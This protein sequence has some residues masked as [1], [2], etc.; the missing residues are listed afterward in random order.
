MP[1]NSSIF[2]TDFATPA[3][4]AFA[5]KLDWSFLYHSSIPNSNVMTFLWFP[6]VSPETVPVPK[7]QSVLWQL[8]PRVTG[9]WPWSHGAMA[10]RSRHPRASDGRV[11]MGQ[12]PNFT[13]SQ[14]LINLYKEQTKYAETERLIEVY[15]QRF[16]IAL[17]LICERHGFWASYLSFL[18]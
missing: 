12:V 13:P 11:R 14:R 10:Y 16:L 6:T 9:P 1:D 2:Q 7:R 15:W 4:S 5:M 17:V 3:A 8:P 18:V